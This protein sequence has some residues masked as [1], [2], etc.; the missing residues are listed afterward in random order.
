MQMK[1][2]PA[3]LDRSHLRRLVLTCCLAAIAA[4]LATG[5]WGE[6]IPLVMVQ[7]DS[8]AMRFDRMT[9]VATV[10]PQV[11]DVIVTGFYELVVM[12]KGPGRTKL[13][14][15]DRQGRHDYAVVVKPDRK[16]QEAQRQLEQIL[17]RRF[18]YTIL[19]NRTLLIKGDVKDQREQ[20]EI[21]KVAED[22][23]KEIGVHL[24]A[25]YFREDLA[26]T[27]AQRQAQVLRQILGDRFQYVVWDE[28]TVMVMGEVADAPE[29]AEIEALVKAGSTGG[30]QVANLVTIGSPREP[31][32]VLEIAQALG[33]EY[34]V[35]PLRGKTVVVEGVAPDAAAKERVDRIVETFKARAE[36][37]NLVT[38]AEKPGLPL[39]EKRNL[40]ASALGERLQVQTVADRA[41]VVTGSVGSQ[42]ELKDVEQVVALFAADTEVLNLV[43]VV[44][45]AKRQVLVKVQVLDVRKGALDRVGVAWGQLS[46]AGEELSLR[47]PNYSW[48]FRAYRTLQPDLTSP[49]GFLINALVQSNE[50]KVLAQPNLLVNDGDEASI[51]VGGEVPIPVPQ[52]SGGATAITIEYKPF[53][54]KLDV[55]PEI[56]G[57]NRINLLVTPE[58]SDIDP[59][60]SVVVAGLSIPGFRTRRESTTTEM[61]SGDTLAIGGLIQST[62]SKVINKVPVLGDIPILGQLF[63]SKEFQTG[64]SELVIF[65]TPEI[66]TAEEM[67][68]RGQAA[69]AR[70]TPRGGGGG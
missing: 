31:A 56:V 52:T 24:V 64:E 27:P 67:G 46:G 21:Q 59:S 68:A 63:R 14:V 26:M 37:V 35:W 17:P 11:V 13:Y 19:D 34:R 7:G 54:V 29:L 10:D 44:S 4:G 50:A 58:V 8:Q 3:V 38:V 18:A 40:L 23:A 41:L 61:I 57:E 62:V 32:P 9:R 45:P 15:W 33:P 22:V 65:V 43:K 69:G 16:A 42:A 66:V 12:A 47:T 55:K 25:V 49:V 53:G 1:P 51:L 48:L 20:D 6:S 2:P 70:L 36:V 5:S 28:K 60:V 39:A 30:V